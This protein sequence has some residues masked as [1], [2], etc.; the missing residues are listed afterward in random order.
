MAGYST[1]DAELDGR[2]AELVQAAGVDPD[3]DLVFEMV[4]SALRLGREAVDRGELKLVN[5]ALKELRYSFSVFDPYAA[6]RKVAIFG[7]ARIHEDSAEYEVA[8]KVGREMA[9]AGW[10]IITGAGPGIM[11]AGIEGAGLDHSFGVSIMLPFESVPP[12]LAAD[13]KLVNF[14]YF[15]TR[16]VTFVKES[17]GFVLLPGGFGT[18]DEAFEL[19]TLQ[20]TGHSPVA[21]VV[22]LDP[23]GSTYWE[24]WRTF[25]E[26]ELAG[27]GLVS[28]DDLEL[29]RVAQTVEEAVDELCGFYR[30]FHSTRFV[31]R[32]LVIRLVDEIDDG[33]LERLN[34]EFGDLLAGG[35]IERT[36]PSDGEVRDDDHVDLPRLALRFDR[37]SHARL[38]V[39]IDVIN[40]RR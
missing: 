3:D 38:R 7:S 29:V 2:I 37:R 33:L 19:L 24:G 20:Q 40:G 13:P 39:M 27:R 28:P 18:M 26:H 10:M 16:K 6:V 1:G 34:R 35:S 4:V 36:G 30:V 17:H 11:Q 8:R 15:F 21:P 9:E 23:P 5:S 32:R 25:I 14:R 12:F 22:L 31:G